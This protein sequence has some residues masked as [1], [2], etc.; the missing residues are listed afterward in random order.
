MVLIIFTFHSTLGLKHEESRAMYEKTNHLMEKISKI[1]YFIIMNSSIL[2]FVIPIAI[3]SYLK[4]YT[5]NL[6]EDAFDLS[7]PVWYVHE[8]GPSAWPFQLFN[9]YIQFQYCFVFILV[10]GF[11]LT[12]KTQ[13]V[14]WLPSFYNSS[15]YHIQYVTWQRFYLLHLEYLCLQFRSSKK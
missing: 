10:K 2:G 11:H 14:I 9:Q 13:S 4:Y 5:T 1:V 12:I 8:C 6:G 3:I 7:I 15:S